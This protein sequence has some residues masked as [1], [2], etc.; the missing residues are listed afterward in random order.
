MYSLCFTILLVTGIF[1]GYCDSALT[2]CATVNAS[3]T[4]TILNIT[5][6]KI[7][8]SSED[9][10]IFDGIKDLTCT[11]GV[12]TCYV[13]CDHLNGSNNFSLAEEGINLQ[14]E[15]NTTLTFMLNKSKAMC[16][17]TKCKKADIMKLMDEINKTL[18]NATDLKRLLNIKY[19]CKRLFQPADILFVHQY[20]STEK[21]CIHDIISTPFKE[22]TKEFDLGNLAMT[23]FKMN[24]T[25]TDGLVNISGPQVFGHEEPLKI[26][27]PVEPFMNVSEEQ[28]KVA[29]V[30][31]ESGDLFL[32]GQRDISL[33]TTVIRIEAVGRTIENLMQPLTIS[34]TFADNLSVYTNFYMSCQYYDDNDYCWKGEGFLQKQDYQNSVNCSY[35]HMTPFAVLL[36]D[37]QA[38]SVHWKILS[39]I[40]YIGCGVS[41]LFS[42]ATI[43]LYLV[44][45]PQKSDHSNSIHVSL[46]IALL[47]LNASFLFS[48][49]VASLSLEGFCVFVAVMIEY[50]LLCCFSWMTIEAFHLYLLVVKVFNTYIRYY[51][52][53]L[54]LFAWGVPAVLV[55]TSLS[56]YNYKAFY[57]TKK[58]TLSDTNE[59][60]AMCWILDVKFLYG[61][62]LTYFTLTFLL[63]TSVL[64]TVTCQIC[65]LQHLG[66]K[67]RKLPTCKEICMVLGLTCLL[68]ITWGLAFLSSG[69]TNYP[70]LYLFC[71]C[72]TLQ[73]LFMFLWV[74]GTIRKN[75]R[76]AAETI[77]PSIPSNVTD[78]QNE[79]SSCHS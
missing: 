58:V 69:Y 38:D 17:V 21:K 6:S 55:A 29:I 79:N 74:Y 22:E 42:A 70:I 24:R 53:K 19:M 2:G 16:N 34:F 75:R 32:V 48:E 73:G 5:V 30:T 31:Y 43:L 23:V 57:G 78:K 63:N 49:W 64:F 40:S 41:V 35:D 8:C 61:M 56:V 13:E 37:L 25:V 68:G 12:S 54:S 11:W 27:I 66:S 52:L 77:S 33:L 65:K 59:T 1:A 47:L 15:D 4:N 10:F 72:N 51:M 50:S 76:L 20:I 3:Y 14:S 36:I 62:N 7:N 18:S 44:K 28:S 71:I 39:Y 9:V 26:W 67:K 46:S 45:K 60:T